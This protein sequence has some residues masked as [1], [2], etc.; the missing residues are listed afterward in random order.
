MLRT[1]PF[2]RESYSRLILTV[3]VQ[4]Y[5]RCSDKFQDLVS[6]KSGE[7]ED[8]APRLSLA[9]QWAQRS[10]LI[11]CLTE[12]F[13]VMQD[14]AAANK[15]TQLCR[16]ETH[17]EGN[18]L[19]ERTVGKE[20]LVRT[21]RNLATLTTLYHSVVRPHISPYAFVNVVSV[22]MVLV[23]VEYFE[24]GTG[25]IVVSD[26]PAQ[27]GAHE[28]NDA[29][30]SVRSCA[31]Y[32]GSRT[33]SATTVRG[34]GNVSSDVYLIDMILIFFQRR[35][36]ALQ[37]TYEQLSESIL[38]T[39]R[40]DIRCRVWHHLDLAL[41]H[42]SS[43]LRVLLHIL[44]VCGQ[45]NYFIDQEASEPDPHVVDLNADLVKCD[46]YASSTLPAKERR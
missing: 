8:V 12:L 4:F 27:T 40:V 38:H 43:L 19:G 2:H 30:H 28:R 45:G 3:I 29:L 13:H 17:L 14:H 36:S 21:T 26:D 33:T 24:V 18:L 6:I 32:A 44:T 1:T 39:V 22:D 23:R 31:C 34:D 37:K 7:N 35:F 9:A 46:D 16:Q 11:P 20:E 5:Q 10:E 15:R 41:R 25:G 42:V